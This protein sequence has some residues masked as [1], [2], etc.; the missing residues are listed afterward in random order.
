MRPRG[1]R[2][3][4]PG[5]L[6]AAYS[7]ALVLELGARGIPWKA[8]VLLPIHYK[9]LQLGVPMRVDLVCGDLLVELKARS[10]IG[11]NERSQLL[12]YLRASGFRRGLLLNFGAPGLRFE[13][14]DLEP[15]TRTETVQEAGATA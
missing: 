2:E 9:G 5:F 7:R 13:R 1:H 14:I 11:R 6:E 3:L 4:G 8:E 12:Q 15:W 10:W